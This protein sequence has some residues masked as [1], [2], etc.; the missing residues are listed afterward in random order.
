[1]QTKAVVDLVEDQVS[2]PPDEPCYPEGYVGVNWESELQQ[3][4]D[5]PPKRKDLPEDPIRK[6]LDR[7]LFQIR[8]RDIVSIKR[9]EYQP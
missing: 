2:R 6:L 3:Y 4:V 7:F 1:M 5:P 9:K 8:K